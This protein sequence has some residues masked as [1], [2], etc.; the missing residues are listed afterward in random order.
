MTTEKKKGRPA[1]MDKLKGETPAQASRRRYRAKNIARG[2]PSDRD[3]MRAIA[4]EV[5]YRYVQNKAMQVP[6]SMFDETL[7]GIM[8]GAAKELSRNHEGVRDVNFN[9]RLGTFL[10]NIYR[11]G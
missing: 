5:A 2:T 9:K 3:V 10:Q 6:Y 8:E 11:K 1:K 7:R 4:L